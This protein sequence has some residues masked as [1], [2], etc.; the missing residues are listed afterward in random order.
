[1]YMVNIVTQ[2]SGVP[3]LSSELVGGGYN[4][5]CAKPQDLP[6]GIVPQGLALSRARGERSI[7]LRRAVLPLLGDLAQAMY[8]HQLERLLN[9]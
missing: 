2:S 1:M 6:E 7:L 4:F 3:L 9:T 8:S 5:I